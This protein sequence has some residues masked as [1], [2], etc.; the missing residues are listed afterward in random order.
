MPPYVSSFAMP[1]SRVCISR[2][3]CRPLSFPHF[4]GPPAQAALSR[5]LEDLRYYRLELQ[6]R[7]DNFNKTFGR[8]PVVGSIQQVPTVCIR[9]AVCV[10][11]L[12]AF[13]TPPRARLSAC[14]PLECT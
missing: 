3:T 13:R 11:L 5:A 4:S 6:N 2:R 7:E 10:T 9:I 1:Y 12:C 8:S 14:Q